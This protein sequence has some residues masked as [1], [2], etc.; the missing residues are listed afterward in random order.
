M[1]VAIVGMG[2]VGQAYSKMFPE[3]VKYDP[4]IDEYKSTTKDDVNACDV[5]LVA[6]FTPYKEDGSLDISIVEEVVDW[7]ECP[8][9]LIKSALQPGTVDYL[10][11]KTGKRIAVSVELIG[12]GKYYQPDHKYPSQS[13]PKKHQYIVVGGELDVAEE[14]AEL[15][16]S[17]MSPDIKIHLVTALEAELTKLAENTYG[18]LKVTWANVLRDVC[19]KFG[20]SFVRVH[21]AWSEDGRVDGMHT[22]SVSFNRGWKSKCYSKDCVAFTNLSGSK[23]LEGMIEDN[24]RHYGLTNEGSPYEFNK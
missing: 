8:L 12:E 14:A 3:A 11:K 5:A 13:N 1:K 18:A 21:Q 9:I 19:D 23:M 16:W 22:R 6:V 24:E 2:V 4:F 7:I 15:L 10:V 20:V 17:R